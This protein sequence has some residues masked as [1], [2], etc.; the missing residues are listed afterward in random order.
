MSQGLNKEARLRLLRENDQLA[1]QPLPLSDPFPYK[2][3]PF[4]AG[5]F[6]VEFYSYDADKD[7]SFDT[8]EN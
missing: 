7:P 8:P 4:P 5:F 1:K 6:G 3:E 2:L